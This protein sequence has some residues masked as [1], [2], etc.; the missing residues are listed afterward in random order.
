MSRGAQRLAKTA[1]GAPPARSAF[2]ARLRAARESKGFEHAY[3]FADRL[4]VEH[5]T[6]RSWERA[7]REPCITHLRDIALK[8]DVSL[9]YLIIG[10]LPGLALKR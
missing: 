1:E 8:L 6:Y 9:D 5:E 10:T 2:G 3:Q 4:G 7:D